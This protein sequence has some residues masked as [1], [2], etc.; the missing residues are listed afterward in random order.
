M[1]EASTRTSQD[2]RDMPLDRLIRLIWEE[3]EAMQETLPDALARQWE[4]S[5]SPRPL[6][7]GGGSSAS[8]E[9]ADPTADVALDPRRLQVR[10]AV[11]AAEAALRNTVI[12]M[13]G[14]RLA[15]ERAVERFDGGG[16]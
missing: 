8:G 1:T 6:D 7:S 14:S 4:Q 13:R 9:K 5:P 15:I 11:G 3:T 12:T 10:E 2:V 16:A